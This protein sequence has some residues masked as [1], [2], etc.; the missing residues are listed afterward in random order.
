MKLSQFRVVFT[1]GFLFASLWGDF[2]VAKDDTMLLASQGEPAS[3]LVVVAD[4]ASE[5]LMNRSA[6]LIVETVDRWSGAK[7]PRQQLHAPKQELLPDQAI[8]LTTLEALQKVAPQLAAAQEFARAGEIDPEGFVYVPRTVSGKQ[9]LFVVSQTPRGVFNAATYLIDFCIDGTKQDLK[10]SFQPIVRSPKMGGRAAYTLTIWG[11]EATYTPENWATIFEQFARDGVDRVYFWT[12]G[13]FPSQKFPQ[14]YRSKTVEGGKTFDTTEDSKIGTVAD[15]QAIIRSAHKLGLKIYL[16]G[17]L[18]CWCGT[19]HLTN[20]DPDTLKQGPKEPSLCPSNPRARQAIL[21]YYQEMFAALPEA[22][23]LFIESA[24]EVG[25]CTCKLCSKPVDQ[26]GSRQFGQ[27]QLSLCQ[28]LMDAIWRD[29]PHARLSYTIGYPEHTKDVAYYNRIE[30]WNK[31]PR[32]EW[33]EARNSWTFPGANGEPQLAPTRARQV[34]RWKQWYNAPLTEMVADANRAGKE[35]WYGLVWSFE[36]GFA[37]GSFYTD[38]IPFPTELLPYTLT[39]F[40]F[41]ETTWDPNLS[42][43][44]LQERTQRRYFGNDAPGHLAADLWK[45]R[46]MIRTRKG[47]SELKTIEEHIREARVSAG[48]KTTQGLDLMARAVADLHKY[49]TKRQ[50]RR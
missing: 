24:D 7:L 29:H 19:I 44:E 31:D 10:A 41:R 12:S 39:S 47:L 4:K 40:V 30:R 21:D 36:P 18:G 3:Q 46:E 1:L 17:G 13:H 2:A 42:V 34:M 8:V 35:G 26:L 23:G 45:L 49:G 33:M 43:E 6:D 28:E 14:T 20:S 11:D 27:S 38:I 9:Q 22:D 16:G 15:L 32:L 37:T 5:Q 50:P 25:E 48:P